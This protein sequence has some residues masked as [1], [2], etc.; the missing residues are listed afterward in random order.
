[1]QCLVRAVLCACCFVS[2]IPVVIMIGKFMAATTN[3]STMLTLTCLSPLC[4]LHTTTTSAI[5]MASCNGHF[6]YSH[7]ISTSHLCLT[8]GHADGG[9]FLINCYNRIAVEDEESICMPN[10]QG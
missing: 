3:L 10:S 6:D 5:H 9:F 7:C 2:V 4:C 1:M 8:V